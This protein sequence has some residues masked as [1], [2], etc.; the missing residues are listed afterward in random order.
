MAAAFVA[1]T[2]R[3]VGGAGDPRHPF[4]R[5][6][7]GALWSRRACGRDDGEVDA[8]FVD[9]AGF[10]GRGG[11]QTLREPDTVAVV[12]CAFLFGCGGE[13]VFAGA[14]GRVAR[15]ERN[16]EIGIDGDFVFNRDRD[17]AGYGAPGGGAPDAARSDFVD[18]G[19]GYFFVVDPC[20]VDCVVGRLVRG[21]R[22]KIEVTAPTK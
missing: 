19:G 20:G 3:I 14:C 22:R 2:I 18:F 7:D 17:F 1:A 16:G 13:H 4:G 5:G 9:C 15:V 12:Y 11:D 10:G 6:S 21:G 8:G